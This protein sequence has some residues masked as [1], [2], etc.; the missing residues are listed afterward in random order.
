MS[1]VRPSQ[2]HS[3]EAPVEPAVQTVASSDDFVQLEYRRTR[4]VRTALIVAGLW[5]GTFLLLTAYAHDFMA[6]ALVPGLTVAYALGLSQ[7]VLV[8]VVTAAYLRTST[9]T[10]APLEDR[11]LAVLVDGTPAGGRA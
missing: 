4:F 7:F 8:W 1:L 10:F 5:F 9:R 2:G 3:H 11:A 6:H